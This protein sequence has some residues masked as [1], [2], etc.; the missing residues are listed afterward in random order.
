MNQEVI[1]VYKDVL[2]EI[3]LSSTERDYTSCIDKLDSLDDDAYEVEKDYK[4]INRKTQLP[5]HFLAALRILRFSLILKKKLTT[6]Y[7]VFMQAY[8][9]L[10]SKTKREKDEEQLLHEIRDFLYNVDAL[11]GDFDRLAMRLVQEIHAGIL[12]LFGSAPEMNAEFYKGRFNDESLTKIHPLLNE[13]LIHCDRFEEEIR[14]MK[15]LDRV[16]ALILNR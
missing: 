7:D 5:G 8:Q 2:K 16:R 15:A 14:I 6:R 4:T 10:S 13:L 9:K 3:V 12:F 1:E 11:L